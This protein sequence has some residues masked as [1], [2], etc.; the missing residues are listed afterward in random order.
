MLAL[1]ISPTFSDVSIAKFEQVN[2]AWLG[3]IL[4]LLLLLLL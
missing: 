2:T 3:L 1:N 4:L